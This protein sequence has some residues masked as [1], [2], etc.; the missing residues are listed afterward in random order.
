M[1]K[2]AVSMEVICLVIASLCVYNDKM[3]MAIYN[4]LLCIIVLLMQI[5]FS[6]MR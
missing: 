3:D 2:F 6:V 1:K 5:K 4:S